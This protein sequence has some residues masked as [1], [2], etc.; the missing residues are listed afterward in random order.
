MRIERSDRIGMAENSSSFYLLKTVLS[1][2]MTLCYVLSLHSSKFP[3]GELSINSD[4]CGIA[5]PTARIVNGLLAARSQLPWMVFLAVKIN[6]EYTTCSGTILTQRNILTA[7]HCIKQNDTYP[8]RIVAFYNS[9]E[10]LEGAFW[11]VDRMKVHPDFNET[12]FVNDIAILRVE[13]PFTFTITTR[14]ICISLEPVD[15]FHKH[16]RVAGWGR[17]K[18]FGPP[19]RLL[20]YTSLRVLSDEVC[21]R[22]FGSNGYNITLQFCAYED[23]T[24]ACEGDSG[25]PAIARAG[26]HR[27]LQVGIVSYGAACAGKVPGVYTR[28]DALVPWILDNIL[29]G[30]WQILYPRGEDK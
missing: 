3:N 21:M 27:F 10:K 17:L 24:D 11:R 5:G 1:W 9:T 30:T 15:I 23:T 7:A 29:Y 2:L 26:N 4:E 12:T 14:P 8:T 6:G 19:Q 20:Y 18:Q 22:K 28:L 16:V 13:Q 25:G